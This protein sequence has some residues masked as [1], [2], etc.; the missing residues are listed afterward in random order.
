MRN[1]VSWL[2]G[3]SSLEG[4]KCFCCKYIFTEVKL[5]IFKP[6]AN[7]DQYVLYTVNGDH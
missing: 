6:K 5:L 1:L 3:E 2:K 4:K 7:G